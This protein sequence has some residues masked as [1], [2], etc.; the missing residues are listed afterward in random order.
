MN[1]ENGGIQKVIPKDKI[2]EAW[3]M[4]EHLSEGDISVKDKDILTLDDL[5]GQDFY[6]LF[7]HEIEKRKLNPKQKGGIVVY[8]DVFSFQEV[9]SILR[10]Q[11]GLKPTD[12]EI[13]IGNKFSFALYFDMN[14]DFIQDMTFFTESAYIRYYKKVPHEEEFREFEDDFKKQI[15]QDFDETSKAPEKFNAAMQKEILRYGIDIK[16]CRIQILKNIE[17]EA[18]NLHS[19]FIDDLEKA[20]KIR[21]NN[22][23]AYL[24][25]NEEGRVNL[26]SK[27]NSVNFHPGA[28]EQ[29]LQPKNYP[30]GRFPSNT[31]YALSLMQ[32]IAVNLSIGFD[33]HQMRSVN[34]PP[35]TGKTTLLKDIF[36]QLV[37]QQ[38][39]D[40]AKLSDHCIKGTEETIYFGHASIG[41]IPT[42]INENNI[43][44]ASSNNGAVQNIV[45]ELPLSKEIDKALIGE[46]KQADYFCEISNAK[47]SAEWEEDENGKKQEVLVSESDQGE[48]KF[49]G[50]F[51]LEGGKAGNMTNI[52]T[53]MKHVH[54][55]L[56]EEYL[57]DSDVYTLF[58]KQYEE[59]KAIRTKT[60]TVADSIQSYKNCLQKL[61]QARIAYQKASEQKEKELHAELQKLDRIKRECKLRLEQL[62]HH[63]EMA[64]NR[65]ETAQKSRTSLELCLQVHTGQKPGFFARKKEKEEYKRRLNE[66]MDQLIK[67]K[68]EILECGKQE[69]EIN[70][71]ITTCQ[72]ELDHSTEK[73]TELRKE[74]ANWN[75]KEEGKILYMEKQVHEYERIKNDSKAE[76]LNMNLEYNDLQLSN[77]WFDESYRIAQSKLFVTA[78]RVRKQFLYENR[79]NI[80]AATIIWAQQ[81][82]YLDQK[83]VIEAAWNWINMTIPVISSTFASFS[84]MC[85]NLGTET[86]G[87][88]FIDEAG[89]ALPQ[90]AIGAIYRSRHV[91]VVGD[92]SQI[93][94]V[95]TL[96]SNTLHMLGSH[97]GVTEKYLSASASVQTL[98]DAASRYGFYRKQDQSGDSWIGIPLWVHRRC[99]YPMFTISNVISY[100]GFMVQ[101]M[102][103]NGKTG[104]FDISGKANNK[105]VEEQGEFLLQKI[106]EMMDQ[107]PEISDKQEKDTIYVITPFSN[108]AYQLS[109]KLRKIGFTRYD[110]HGK[111]TNIGTV[112]TFQGKEAPIVFFVLGADQQSSGAARWAVNESNMMNVAATRAKKEFYIIG[113]KKLYLGLGC[114]V[115]T[116]TD[117]IIRQYKKQ[118]P[119]LVDEDVHLVM[120][121]KT[122]V[123]SKTD[124]NLVTGMIRYVGKGKKGSY[125][126]VAGN[127]GKEYSISESIYSETNQAEEVIQKGNKISFVPE[128][129][130]KKLLATDVKLKGENESDDPQ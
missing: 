85:R 35:G 79:K 6:S 57:P 40:I 56:E 107:N 116:N 71:D 76:P 127:D 45:N 95:L 25:G 130:E 72:A 69:S 121:E 31:T 21:T 82:K 83:P 84:R 129:G 112:H 38:A 52:L 54:K 115:V 37:V 17:T 34:G 78:L 28:F 22:L 88:L 68:D 29:I 11:Y 2:L 39:Y 100:D 110:D 75:R 51:S 74:S 58:L 67:L 123:S 33:N 66:I 27:K 65:A 94:P 89:Q 120:V 41:E 114:D 18:T 53:N 102:E 124:F 61:E 99:Q 111:P 70:H 113:D 8:F 59:V 26:D 118:F 119:D 48:E 101:G 97:F 32:Q 10:E 23:N 14:F 63:L 64:K 9:V 30:L 12:E 128:N 90:S 96:D 103:K 106:R 92:P 109:Q 125:A 108:V 5:Q 19:F 126:Y 81:E 104:W 15:S 43:V 91:M 62:Q 98:V 16:N 117:R 44:V 93:K 46:L 47:V 86:L 87:H 60:Q 42:N 7:L 80:K 1:I 55:Y 105:Y 36:A 77:P 50:L 3:I 24:Y 13:N 73:Q 4:V 122:G 49:W 20:K